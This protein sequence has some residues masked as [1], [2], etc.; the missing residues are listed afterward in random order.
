MALVT[1]SEE[2]TKRF[3]TAAPDSADLKAA[4]QKDF[5]AVNAKLASFERIKR[6]AVLPHELT[7]AAGE[8]T[9][10][11]SIKRKVVVDK[12]RQA[13]EGLYEGHAPHA[14]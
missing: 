12:Y 13:L 14:D 9:P 1:L 3:G 7:E 8:L 2:A 4:L 6:F 10:K 5:D 11:L